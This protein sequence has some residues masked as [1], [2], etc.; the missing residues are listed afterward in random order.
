MEDR[1]LI[2]HRK[3]SSQ[4]FTL[5][6]AGSQAPLTYAFVQL[7]SHA[8]LCSPMDYIACCVPLSIKFSSKNNGAGF[9]FLL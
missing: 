9:L 7:F 5:I 1:G 2:I 3:R 6:C 8:H 4:K